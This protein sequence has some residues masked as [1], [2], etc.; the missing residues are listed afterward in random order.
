[1]HDISTDLA[2]HR[3]LFVVLIAAAF[4]HTGRYYVLTVDK[5][6]AVRVDRWTGETKRIDV[7]SLKGCPAGLSEEECEF[8]GLR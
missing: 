3:P 5:G 6:V 4:L 8:L 2:M 7:E 1:M